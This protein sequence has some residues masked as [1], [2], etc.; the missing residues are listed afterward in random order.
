MEKFLV[1]LMNRLVYTMS[2]QLVWYCWWQ[3]QSQW[4]IHLTAIFIFI[5]QSK[6]LFP[7]KIS[8][9][10][11]LLRHSSELDTFGKTTSWINSNSL[12]VCWEELMIYLLYYLQQNNIEMN[13]FWWDM[14]FAVLILLSHV[15]SVNFFIWTTFVFFFVRLFYLLTRF[16]YHL[17]LESSVTFHLVA[18]FTAFCSFSDTV[19]GGLGYR[20]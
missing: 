3:Q 5:F 20:E 8:L 6:V 11:L 16:L 4:L 15:A 7:G 19:N 17:N 1:G 13:I 9:F 14:M 18:E 12:I 2:Y 10:F